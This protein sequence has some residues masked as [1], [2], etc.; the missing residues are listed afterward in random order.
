MVG[1]CVVVLDARRSLVSAKGTRKPEST[2]PSQILNGFGSDSA[3]LGFRLIPRAAGREVKKILFGASKG[4]IQQ[5]MM[6]A[7]TM[8]T[9]LVGDVLDVWLMLRTSTDEDGGL[10]DRA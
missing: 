10:T 6:M 4:A 5:T 2:A 8:P 7:S 3:M 9:M 1:C